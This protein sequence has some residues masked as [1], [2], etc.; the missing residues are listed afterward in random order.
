MRPAPSG[1]DSAASGSSSDPAAISSEPPP[2]SKSRICP[3]AHPNQRRTAR[4]VKRASVSPPST[5]RLWPSAASMRAI[6]SAPFAASRTAEVAVASSS[7]TFSDCRDPAR[8]GDRGHQ[9]ADA[10]LG[11]RAV[12][13]EVA[14]EAQHGALAR[15]RERPPARAHIGDEQVDGVRADVEDSE[16]HSWSVAR[17][18]R[19][20]GAVRHPT[21][22]DDRDARR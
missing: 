21:R 9:G 12:G 17:G 2:M 20:G 4:N 1:T 15:G 8:L 19:R 18:A 22:Y 13:G 7:S 5:C 3:A 16:A 11:D 6:T 10:L 14:H